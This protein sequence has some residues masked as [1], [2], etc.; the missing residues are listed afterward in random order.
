MSGRYHW[1]KGGGGWDQ[2][3]FNFGYVLRQADVQRISSCASWWE[4]RPLTMPEEFWRGTGFDPNLV[5]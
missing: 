1:P 2:I 4:G 5:L 3:A